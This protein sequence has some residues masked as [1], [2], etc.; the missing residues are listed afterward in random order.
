LVAVRVPKTSLIF[1]EAFGKLKA[2]L[3]DRSDSYRLTVS[4]KA[5]KEACAPAACWP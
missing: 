4:S 5:L 1:S 2:T 3:N